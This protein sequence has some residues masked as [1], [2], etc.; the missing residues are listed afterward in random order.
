MFPFDDVIMILEWMDY[1][2]ARLNYVI[3]TIFYAE[4]QRIDAKWHM[5]A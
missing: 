2:E 5:Y 3:I 4:H 1:K